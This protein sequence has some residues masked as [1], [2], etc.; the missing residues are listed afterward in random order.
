MPKSNS[1]R[2]VPPID[3]TK[4]PLPTSGQ[5]NVNCK[6]VD[7]SGK[8]L[9]HLFV[10][11]ESAS[12]PNTI[13][14]TISDSVGNVKFSP[15]ENTENTMTVYGSLEC[16]TPVFTITFPTTNRDTS[17]GTFTI[18]SLIMANISGNVVDCNNKPVSGHIILQKDQENYQFN[19][20][21]G[22][23]NFSIPI[24]NSTGPESVTI[25]AE[26]NATLEPG[27]PVTISLNAGNNN[28]GTL[29]A[30]YDN[31]S[32]Q[33]YINYTFDSQ[34]Y[35]IAPPVDTIYEGIDSGTHWIR[36][37]GFTLN[38][39]YNNYIG[40]VINGSLSV[41]GTD[42]SLDE[43]EIG[44]NYSRTSE[45]I[46]VN[47]TEYGPVGNGFIAGNFHTN[48][49][50]FQNPQDSTLHSTKVNFRVKRKS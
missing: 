41:G 4:I 49:I 9:S 12:Y 30:C 45:P 39:N 40:F 22:I 13:F 37:Y 46:I 32:S 26:D 1:S 25:I 43:F 5:V 33:E 11:V 48:V 31:T 23:F 10:K 47:I 34:S 24:C 6:L 44:N 8:T 15:Y 38:T 28:V 36:I 42:V 50:N 18:S 27:S 20:S 19:L 21:N 14:T 29:K 35:S 7:S 17:I 3:T 2:L 16:N